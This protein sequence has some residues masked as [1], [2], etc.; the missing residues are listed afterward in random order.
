[1]N[2]ILFHGLFGVTTNIIFLHFLL[3]DDHKAD[4]QQGYINNSKLVTKSIMPKKTFNIHI[5]TD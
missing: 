3:D 5:I 2:T 1:M 4:G